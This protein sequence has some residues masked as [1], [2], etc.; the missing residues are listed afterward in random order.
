MGKKSQDNGFTLVEIIVTIAITTL[1]IF[2]FS[3][4]L[5]KAFKD[6]N[7]Q[8][9][10][11]ENIYKAR[12]V[13]SEFSNEMRNCV[14]GQD[15]SYPI[16]KATNNEII[17][18]SN[19]KAGE[20]NVKR[21]RYYINNTILYKGIVFA[22]GNPFTYNLASEV[23]TPVANSVTNGLQP[24]FY[25]YDGN[26]DGTGQHLQQPVNINN[27]RYINISLNVLKETT[28]GSQSEFSIIGGST[29][30]PLKDNLDN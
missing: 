27:I 16:S 21:I 22:S 17:F 14:Y 26:Y 19:Y 15:G 5:I 30:R 23:V 20:G 28:E 1:L 2:L 4:L 24:V 10:A 3:A 18:F 11:M 13:V 29:I 7:Q 25:Y 12:S 8:M 6:P 9:K